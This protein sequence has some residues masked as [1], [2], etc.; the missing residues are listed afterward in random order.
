MLCGQEDGT[1]LLVPHSRLVTGDGTLNTRFADIDVGECSTPQC[2]DLDGDGRK[3]LII[4][5][6]RGLLSYYRNVGANIAEF[7]KITDTLGGVDMRDYTQSYFG[8]SVPCLYRDAQQGTVLFCAGES[9]EVTYYKQIDGNLDGVFEMAESNLVET[10]NGMAQ[11]FREGRR[12]A[13]AVADLNGD[14]RPDM[15][16][17]NYA[18]GAAYFE[19]ATPPAHNSIAQHE[20]V[21]LRV[22]PNPAN[23]ILYLESDQPLEAVS[24]YDLF[25]RIVLVIN[26]IEDNGTVIN[27]SSLPTGVYFVRTAHHAVSKFIKAKS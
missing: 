11:P 17:G 19:G 12:V 4:G 6:R 23:H 10:V 8:Y 18:G 13:A 26:N 15:V 5:N 16:L 9:G 22:Y 24:I 7:Q 14:G 27:T 20:S 25:G 3:D 21:P 2:F 1:L